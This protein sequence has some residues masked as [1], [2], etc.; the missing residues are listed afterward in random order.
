MQRLDPALKAGRTDEYTA[1][2]EVGFKGNYLVRFN[3]VRKMDYGGNKTF[4]LAQPFAAFTDARA[5]IDPGRDNIP[6]TADDR[7]IL[8]YS[9]PRNY[10]TFGQV[11]TL[12]TNYAKNE[13]N[14]L[15]TAYE[16]TVNKRFS[17]GW[18]F[19]AGYTADFAKVSSPM[20]LNPNQALYRAASGVGSQNDWQAPFWSYSLKMSATYDLPWGFEW[21]GTYNAQSGETYGRTIQVQNALNAT[22]NIQI[23][24]IAGR[25]PWVKLFDN[26]ISKVIRIG[27]RQSIEGQFDLFNSLNSSAIL[28]WGTTNGPNY[29]KPLSTGGIDASAASPIVAPRV[30]RLAV[31]YRF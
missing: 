12:R 14:R 19:L 3:A 13:R 25:Y 31:R 10:P 2:V 26:R 11:N 20:P 9:V 21:A 30:F 15:Y 6:N 17:N 29:H 23:E 8:V 5:G 27:D 16:T 7:A 1:G 24:S 22:L 28:T 4:D 18:S